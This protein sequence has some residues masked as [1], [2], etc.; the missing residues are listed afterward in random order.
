MKLLII[1][2]LVIAYNLDIGQAMLSVLNENPAFY[3]KR[4]SY[5]SFKVFNSFQHFGQSLALPVII[6]ISNH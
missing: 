5:P 2:L 1:A 3:P 6:L 4:N